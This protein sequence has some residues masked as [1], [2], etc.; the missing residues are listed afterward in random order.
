MDE[1]RHLRLPVRTAMVVVEHQAILDLLGIL[2]HLAM[3]H[4]RVMAALTIGIGGVVMD[5]DMGEVV[6]GSELASSRVV[7]QPGNDGV[8]RYLV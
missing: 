8:A 2:D 5:M 3:A 1:G 7:S 6:R 4:L